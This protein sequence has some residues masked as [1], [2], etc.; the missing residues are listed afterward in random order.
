MGLIVEPLIAAGKEGIK[1]TCADNQICHVFPILASY[2]AD[3][4]EQCLVAGNKENF[5]PI[6]E[7]VPEDCGEP[8]NTPTCDP[9]EVLEAL[10]TSA[11]G[12]P[13]IP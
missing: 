7:V 4:P 13:S 6:C 8:C 10:K 2:I 3:Y 5:C 12:S 11:S 1:M 9:K